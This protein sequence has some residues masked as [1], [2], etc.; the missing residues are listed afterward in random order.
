MKADTEIAIIGAGPYGLSLAAFLRSYGRDFRI[1]G[2]PMQTWATQMPHGMHL[3]SEGFASSLYDRESAF[4]LSQYCR[5]AG[6]AYSDIG[7]PVALETFVGYGMEFQ[8]RQVPNLEKKAVVSLERH[9]AGFRLRLDDGREVTAA[10]VVVAVGISHYGYTPALLAGLPKEFVTHSSEHSDLSG[11]KNREVLIVGSG[12]SAIDLAGL[13]HETG[14]AVQLAARKQV[15]HFHNPPGRQP[16]SLGQRLRA[17]MTGLGPGWRSYFCTSA[18][19][20]FR[21]LPEE[22]R[23]NVVRKHLGPAPG[24]FMKQR[25]MGKMPLHLGHEL[26]AA[27]IE[28]GKVRLEFSREGDAA[29]TILTDHVIAGT[30]YRVDLRR[31]SFLQPILPQVSAAEHTPRLSSHFESSVA[32]LYFVGAS[33]ANTFGPL[34]RFAFGAGFTAQRLSRHL[35]RA[36]TDMVLST[37]ELAKAS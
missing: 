5:E 22:F 24:W 27:R 35:A 36:K 7:K 26:R 31:L 3:K 17:P 21:Q 13:L 18:P 19:L 9:L 4:P 1:F 10:K 34:V 11:F 6:I 14:A 32:G 29:A 30:G 28:N 16:R 37:A 20:V 8:R 23:M 33:S 2:Y 12:S 25:I 15:I